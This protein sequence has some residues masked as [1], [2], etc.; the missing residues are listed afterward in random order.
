M[1]FNIVCVSTRPR[2]GLP[3]SQSNALTTEAITVRIQ[4]RHPHV[5]LFLVQ[6]CVEMI[7]SWI[8]LRALNRSGNSRR[9]IAGPADAARRIPAPLP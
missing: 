5:V 4:L 7:V 9:Q 8:Q 3:T 1:R 2:R 6:Q